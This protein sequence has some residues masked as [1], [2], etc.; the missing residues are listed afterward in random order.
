MSPVP[1]LNPV[2]PNDLFG[3]C[4][5]SQER[6]A[7]RVLLGIALCFLVA[8]SAEAR[9]GRGGFGGMAG[10]FRGGFPG[11]FGGFRGGF[12]HRFGGFRGGFGRFGRGNQSFIG[13]GFFGGGDWGGG[14]ADPGP[15]YPADFGIP[16]PGPSVIVVPPPM[17]LEPPA[18]PVIREYHWPNSDQDASTPYFSIVTNDRTT[19]YATMVWREGNLLRFTTP[20]GTTSQIV[21]SSISRDLT[22]QANPG[23]NVKAWLP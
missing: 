9:G 17:P 8:G 15:G 10:G 12:P 18:N 23:K 20:G 11:R 5:Y 3:I 16:A 4:F 14:F 7:M 1:L 6:L 21:R 13:N 19:H 22:Y 2:S